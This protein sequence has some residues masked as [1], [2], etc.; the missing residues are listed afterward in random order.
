MRGKKLQEIRNEKGGEK[1]TLGDTSDALVRGNGEIRERG[2]K[3]KKKLQN[4]TIKATRYGRKENED[5][6]K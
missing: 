4:E 5:L 2:E 1:K 6:R 3:E